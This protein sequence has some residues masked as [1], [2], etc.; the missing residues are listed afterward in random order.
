MIPSFTEA[1]AEAVQVYQRGLVIDSQ[2]E[3]APA[4][5]FSS[6]SKGIGD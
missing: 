1:Q 5:T 4:V 2:L 3:D 6:V